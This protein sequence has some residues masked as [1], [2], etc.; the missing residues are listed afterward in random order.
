LQKGGIR[1]R[2]DTP[3]EAAEAKARN[4]AFDE[5]K[6]LSKQPENLRKSDAEIW[7][8]VRAA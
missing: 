7:E 8:L 2:E 3:Q 4:A 1:V 6:Q 5:F